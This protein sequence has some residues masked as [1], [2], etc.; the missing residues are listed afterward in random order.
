MTDAD[1]FK[2]GMRRLASGVSVCTMDET[3]LS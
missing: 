2:R 3:T 1:L